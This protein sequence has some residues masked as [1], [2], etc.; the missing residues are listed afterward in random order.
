MTQHDYS[1]ALETFKF[2]GYPVVSVGELT[3]REIIGDDAADAII[4][5]LRIAQKLKEPLTMGVIS[6][7]LNA[8]KICDEYQHGERCIFLESS[9]DVFKAMRDQMLKEINDGDGGNE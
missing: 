1:S 8:A 9:E 2:A 5:A 3:V 4:H 6:A 7:G